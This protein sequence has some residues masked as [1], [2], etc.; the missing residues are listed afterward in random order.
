MEFN[1]IKL[2]G[3]IRDSEQLKP[4]DRNKPRPD[5]TKAAVERRRKRSKAIAKEGGSEPRGEV[6]EELLERSRQRKRVQAAR[7]LEWQNGI[8]GMWNMMVR[9]L[10]QRR[11]IYAA[12]G[13][14]T[15]RWE[16]PI[17]LEE[18][19][20]L[21]LEAGMITLGDGSKVPAWTRR[22]KSQVRDVHIERWN[23]KEPWTLDNMQVVYMGRVLADGKQ[24]ATKYF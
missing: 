20:A 23:P 14:D 17:T 13:R 24:V 21:W 3:T 2:L 7:G 10:R 15:Y 22:G 5:R 16:F 11:R 4:G 19:T 9:S 1:L 8:E 18:W 6:S 12:Q